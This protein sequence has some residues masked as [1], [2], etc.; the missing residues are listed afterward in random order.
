[1]IGDQDE[2]CPAHNPIDG[3]C[4]YCGA[5]ETDDVPVMSAV[6]GDELR[7]QMIDA[8]QVAVCVSGWFLAWST[9]NDPNE[10][11]L[12]SL[13]AVLPLVQAR[14]AAIRQQARRAERAEALLRQVRERH[15]PIEC[16]NERCKVGRFCPACDPDAING[17]VWPCP[18]A[19]LIDSSGVDLTNPAGDDG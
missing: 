1:M 8:A 5:P 14:E 6:P 19:D 7:Q 2:D 3:K 13:D 10:Q 17:C 11:P 18:E 9:C 4:I 15:K 16:N 12:L